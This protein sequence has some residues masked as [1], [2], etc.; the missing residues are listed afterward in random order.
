MKAWRIY[1]ALLLIGSSNFGVFAAGVYGEI[2]A[3][4]IFLFLFSLLVGIFSLSLAQDDGRARKKVEPA[5]VAE[6]TRKARERCLNEIVAIICDIHIDK[7]IGVDVARA[8]ALALQT[9]SKKDE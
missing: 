1:F 8:Y 2:P 7:G 4:Q 6:I 9:A 5:Q 3:I